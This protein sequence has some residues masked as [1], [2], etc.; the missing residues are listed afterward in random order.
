MTEMNIGDL[1]V[2]IVNCKK[3]QPFIVIQVEITWHAYPSNALF[4]LEKVHLDSKS[5]KKI[6]SGSWW[7]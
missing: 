5:Y 3:I 6:V 1:A 4:Y 2:F 7:T